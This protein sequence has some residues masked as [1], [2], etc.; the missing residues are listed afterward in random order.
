MLYIKYSQD[1]AKL[2][3]VVQADKGF[4]SLDRMAAEVINVTTNSELRYPKGKERVNMCAAIEEIRSDSKL[5]G[6]IEGK[7]EGAVETCQRFNMSLRE[8][9]KYISGNYSL[10]LQ[11]AEKK[12][13]SYWKE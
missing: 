12:V 11:E 13:T 2:Q 6:K 1:K 4:K 10:S 5:E 7:I 9:V 8:T 3:E